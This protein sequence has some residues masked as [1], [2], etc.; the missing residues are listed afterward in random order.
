MA[1]ELISRRTFLGAAGT[2]MLGMATPRI[3]PAGP[4]SVSALGDSMSDLGF[5]RDAYPRWLPHYLPGASVV[6]LGE[7]GD[8]TADVLARCRKSGI[9]DYPALAR[10][11]H[12]PLRPVARVNTARYSPGRM[13]LFPSRTEPAL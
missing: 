7:G 8:S 12:K 13:T 10:R 4:R 6:A 11:L 2:T 1:T 9:V 5:F 3:R